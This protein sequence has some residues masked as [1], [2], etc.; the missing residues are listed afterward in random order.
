MRAA[1]ITLLATSTLLAACGDTEVINP[2]DAGRPDTAL[3][4]TA[5]ADARV[6]DS[7]VLDANMEDATV[8]DAAV[9]DADPPPDLRIPGLTNPVS[10]DYDEHG[11]PHVTCSTAQ[12]C[13]AAQN[14]LH[15]QHRFGQMDIRR[16][17]V[18]GKLAEVIGLLSESVLDSDR[19]SR[20]FI[21]TS[22]G[23][24]LEERLWA[25]AE[26]ATRE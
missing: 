26:P 11:V 4:D 19:R 18:R 3:P 22:D 5:V 8:E 14:Y 1:I 23:S 7:S 24:R 13:F 10:V 2:P 6:D 12:D 17:F 21:A 16:R 9:E 20:Q 25:N 15:A